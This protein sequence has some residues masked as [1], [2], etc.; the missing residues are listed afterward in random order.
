MNTD[1]RQIVAVTGLP[2]LYQLV[3]TKNDGA[4]VKNLADKT[5]KFVSARKHQVTPLESIEIY[6]TSDNIRLHEVFEK[7]KSDD[8]DVPEL[9]SK[10]DN[11]AN[12]AYFKRILP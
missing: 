2:G 11:E 12:K 8:A 1:Y 4:I 9:S 10:K 6:T 5:I 7:M 3:S